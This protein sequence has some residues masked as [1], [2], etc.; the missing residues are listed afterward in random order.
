[1][2]KPTIQ[3]SPK[4]NLL[5]Q[6]CLF[7]IVGLLPTNSN[8]QNYRTIEAYMD[9]FAKNELFVKKS[10]MDYS[11]SIVESQL[12][13]RTKVTA[14]RI[15]EKLENINTMLKT[16]NKGFEGN[17]LLRDSFIK[18]NQKTIDCLKNGSLILNDYDYQSTLSLTE[19]GQN[20]ATKESN[21][22][23][24]YQ[25]LKKYELD[26][27]S[28]ALCYKMNFKKN[29]SK[30]ILEYNA[31]QNI[32]FYKMNVMDERLT[33]VINAKDKKGFSDCLNM[34][35][36]MR[37]EVMVKTS[38]YKSEYRDTSLNDANIEY[39]NFLSGETE[40]L[41]DLFNA[42]LDEYN[43]MQT[44][45]N[46]KQAETSESVAKYNNT[47]RSYNAKKNLFYAVFNDIQTTKD[48]MYDNWLTTNSTFLK[49]NSKFDSLY[50]KYATNN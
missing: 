21:L 46:T 19:I 22:I 11:V 4:S 18:L 8:S 37:E 23:A 2:K 50:E 9:D 42:Y 20:L 28:F 16:N 25:E 45:K 48:K 40:K 10:L 6:V 5:I 47:V 33:Y 1:M 27:R 41:S 12:Y 44:L 39:A 14:V 30:N 49:N 15:I 3:N 43:A 26:K 35:P 7:L 13:S 36:F 34:I 31:Y 17:T 38:E 24:Y 29:M 32:L